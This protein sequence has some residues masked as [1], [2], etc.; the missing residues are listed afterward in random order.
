[1]R[2]FVADAAPCGQASHSEAPPKH[3]MPSEARRFANPPFS[4]FPQPFVIPAQA[5]I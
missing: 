2:F 4:P 1:M 5:G 3:P